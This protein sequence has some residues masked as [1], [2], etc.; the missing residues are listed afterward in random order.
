MLNETL[1]C[2]ESF[3]FLGFVNPKLF[4]SWGG[5]VPSNKIELLR[6][7]YGSLFDIPMLESQLTFI[8]RDSMESIYRE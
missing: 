2:I 4:R 5:K 3:G 8:Y 1:K 7:R 6:E